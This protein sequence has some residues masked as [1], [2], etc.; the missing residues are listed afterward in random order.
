MNDLDAQL[1]QWA[2][3]TVK[4]DAQRSA[5]LRQ[6]I[7]RMFDERLEKAKRYTLWCLLGT[8]VAFALA[9]AAGGPFVNRNKVPLKQGRLTRTVTKPA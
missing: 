2:G 7:T 9:A 8:I 3:R 4:P 5:Q 6:E 1:R